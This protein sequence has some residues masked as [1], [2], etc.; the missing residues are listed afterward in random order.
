MCDDDEWKKN[1]GIIQASKSDFFAQLTV[2]RQIYTF[3]QNLPWKID[4]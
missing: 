3:K 1:L 4:T 2:V